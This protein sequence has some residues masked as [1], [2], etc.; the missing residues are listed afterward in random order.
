MD[1]N[2][3]NNNDK[4]TATTTN[5]TTTERNEPV[6]LDSVALFCRLLKKLDESRLRGG[7]VERVTVGPP[8]EILLLLFLFKSNHFVTI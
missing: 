4:T 8:V 5:A 2:N 7:N 6:G 3:N 1:N